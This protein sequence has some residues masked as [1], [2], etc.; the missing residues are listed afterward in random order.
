MLKN[1]PMPGA[2]AEAR[3]GM[4][5]M[6]SPR[7]A[8]RNEGIVVVRRWEILSF[9]RSAHQHK[10]RLDPLALADS[11]LDTQSRLDKALPV[12]PHLPWQ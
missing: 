5:G 1:N 4:Q 12:S 10:Q 2:S 9:L 7:L 6:F 8:N 11:F 3:G